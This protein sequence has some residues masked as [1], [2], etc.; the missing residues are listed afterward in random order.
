MA[1]SWE[2]ADV[3]PVIAR[4]IEDR[5]TSKRDFVTHDEIT[6]SLVSDVEAASSIAQAMHDRDG[7]HTPDGVAGNMVAWFS[8]RITVGQSDWEH[9][10]DRIKIDDKWA[11]KPKADRS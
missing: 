6:A 2:H 5:Y 4:I 9:R 7:G 11:Y 3:F 8:Q 10:F 1:S